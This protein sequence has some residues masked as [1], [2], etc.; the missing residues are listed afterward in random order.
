MSPPGQTSEEGAVVT[1]EE[2]GES[3]KKEESQP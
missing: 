1:F 3:P 2:G